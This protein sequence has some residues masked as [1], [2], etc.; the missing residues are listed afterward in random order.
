ML[1]TLAVDQLQPGA[2]ASVEATEQDGAVI[3][4]GER[5]FRVTRR[6]R[7]WDR[8]PLGKTSLA[9][10]EDWDL[11]VTT[12]KVDTMREEV[13]AVA[14][15]EDGELVGLGHSLQHTVHALSQR[16]GAATHKRRADRWRQPRHCGAK[17]SRASFSRVLSRFFT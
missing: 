3:R 8:T 7:T 13:L 2:R 17:Q 12:E 15:P 16:I 10:E 14:L 4:V 1:V 11:V 6:L 9:R 5:C